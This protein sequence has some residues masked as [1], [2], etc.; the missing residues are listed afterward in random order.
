MSFSRALFLSSDDNDE[1]RI[2]YQGKNGALSPANV[3]INVEELA[4]GHNN[5]RLFQL[6]QSAWERGRLI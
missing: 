6:L 1:I 5:E 3:Q 4:W 2:Y